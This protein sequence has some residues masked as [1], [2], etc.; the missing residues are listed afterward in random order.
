MSEFPHDI[1]FNSS[2]AKIKTYCLII[3]V[4]NQISTVSFL[5]IIMFNIIIT[6]LLYYLIEFHCW[7]IL[8]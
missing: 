8:Q 1:N 2:D 3:I 5:D 7:Y 6:V 4:N